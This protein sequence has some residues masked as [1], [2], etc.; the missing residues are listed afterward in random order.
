MSRVAS[1]EPGAGGGGAETGAPVQTA[2]SVP[3]MHCAGCMGK[4]ERA[5]AAVP[6]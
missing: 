6:G 4:V 1:L 3:G 2:L 5:L